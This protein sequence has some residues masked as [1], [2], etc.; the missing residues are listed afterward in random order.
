MVKSVSAGGERNPP[1]T[2]VTPGT[3]PSTSAYRCAPSPRATTGTPPRSDKARASSSG[4]NSLG[5][6]D[7]SCV[8]ALRVDRP[9]R[10]E[11]LAASGVDHGE[12]VTAVPEIDGRP[13]QHVEAGQADH[14]EVESLGQALGRGHADP[15]AGEQP[16]AEIDRHGVDGGGLDPHL[17]EEMVQRRH[18]RLDVPAAPGQRELGLDPARR[19]HRDG[20]RFGGRFEGHDVHVVPAV[21]VC[22][23]RATSSARAAHP[24]RPVIL[25]VR[26]SAVGPDGAS[27]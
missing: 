20:D 9:Q 12:H 8:V 14:A 27:G 19:P 24:P 13:L 17:I 11:D 18:Q 10:G 21:L 5:R 15:Q 2:Q 7:L 26:R 23:A 25:I 4:A 16:G 3:A 22:S 6:D 1:M